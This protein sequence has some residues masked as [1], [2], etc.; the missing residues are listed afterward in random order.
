MKT[1]THVRCFLLAFFSFQLVDWH[2]PSESRMK[3]AIVDFILDK[4]TTYPE[5]PRE[6][7]NSSLH[8]LA[9]K[10]ERT[11]K[12]LIQQGLKDVEAA[13]LLLGRTYYLMERELR[14]KALDDRITELAKGR[15]TTPDALER[16]KWYW[17]QT[18]I[19]LRAHVFKGHYGSS[20]R[21]T[22]V[23]TN[24]ESM[25]DAQTLQVR[26]Y[27]PIAEAI[28]RAQKAFMIIEIDHGK[29]FSYNAFMEFGSTD[30]NTSLRSRLRRL[31]VLAQVHCSALD[32]ARL[33]VLSEISTSVEETRRSAKFAASRLIPHCKPQNVT[34]LGGGPT[35]LLSA[36]HCVQNVILTGGEVKVYEGRDAFVQ[37]GSSF[38]RAQIVRLDSRQI[39]MLRFHL[40]TGYEDVYIPLQGE[41]DAH[42]G[43][44]LPNQ[45]FVEVTIKRLESMILD[46]L[47][48]MRTKELLSYFTD[49]KIQ[50]DV[51]TGIFEKKGDALKIGDDVFDGNELLKVT[52]FKYLT[53]AKPEDLIPGQD[54]DIKLPRE[55]KVRSFR[56]VQKD[57]TVDWYQ[58]E[59]H[60]T[61]VQPVAGAFRQLPPVY[62]G[63]QGRTTPSGIIVESNGR[64]R[65]L[66][67]DAVAS[68][69]FR[70]DFS[71][72][73]VIVAL[74]KPA[75]SPS[76]LYITTDEPY[77]VC[78]IEG[79]K[80]SMGM[81]NFGTSPILFA[82]LLAF[83]FGTSL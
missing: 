16:N 14:R 30:K 68:K 22:D 49:S 13:K 9:P 5:M 17:V 39:S 66:S 6:V 36:I 81:H 23:E 25:F 43:N 21:F 59:A 58:F 71:R 67:F 83:A 64:E 33:N 61:G 75:G 34:V 40:G 77:A 52:D 3:A 82:L 57:A 79:I 65:E 31:V 24:F 42:M 50:Y 47:I 4:P 76:H 51:S 41:T 48:N 78:C 10:D 15:Q 28:S 44:T 73:H 63:G 7:I 12:E 70:L 53:A 35:G 55:T 62:P 80:I 26:E 32:Q 11:L 60:D 72:T 20:V 8:K 74:G 45:G 69:L 38:E 29:K 1:P 37:E 18:D 2:V 19:G 46:E 56:L 54:Y 27:I